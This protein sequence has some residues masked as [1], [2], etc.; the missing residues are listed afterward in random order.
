MS[1]N[2]EKL[3]KNIDIKDDRFLKVENQLQKMEN[4]AKEFCQ[5]RSN[6]QIEKFI[7][8]DEYTPI[9]K[10]RHVAHNSFVAM[11]ECR[12]MLVDLERKR[13]KI[14]NLQYAIDYQVPIEVIESG[15]PLLKIPDNQSINI[16]FKD[17]DLDIFDISTQITDIE[18]RLK[19]LFKEIDYMESICNK[20]EEDEIKQTGTGFTDQKLQEREPIYWKERLSRQMHRSQIANQL[21]VG[22]GNYMSVIMGLEDP[23]LPNSPNKIE[24]F[25]FSNPNELAV[26]ALQN[27]NG[28]NKIM[29]KKVTD[30]ELKKLQEVS[31]EQ[32]QG[33]KIIR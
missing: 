15:K 4:R 25:N 10:F 32:A 20:L 6:F 9:T 31:Q 12:R 18:I 17:Y 23:I 11:Q 3:I 14:K 2:H 22:E 8:C 7:A 21:G 24:P 30:E 27:V 26:T 16:H 33:L 1:D 28:V 5:S 19:G 29:L 13:R